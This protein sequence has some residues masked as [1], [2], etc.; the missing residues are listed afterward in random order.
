MKNL[1]MPLPTLPWWRVKTMWLV[2]GGPALVVCAGFATLA[3][4][5]RYGDVP[6]RLTPPAAS[7][8]RH[9]A[10]PDASTVQAMTPAAQARNH[11]VS[12]TR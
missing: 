7:G 12:S 8:A 6:L 2:A 4:A 3:I 5:L 11:V 9:S 10:A 1:D